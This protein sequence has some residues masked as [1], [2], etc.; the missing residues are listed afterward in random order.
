MGC[1]HV[2][3]CDLSHQGAAL[4]MSSSARPEDRGWHLP[5]RHGAVLMQVINKLKKVSTVSKANDGAQ[6]AMPQPIWWQSTAVN[7]GSATLSC[8]AWTN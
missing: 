4:L 7:V 1:S 2:V 6:F 8:F 3:V 5:A